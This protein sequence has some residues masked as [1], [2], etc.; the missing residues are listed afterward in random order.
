M[1]SFFKKTTIFLLF[2]SL[3]LSANFVKAA[4]LIPCG[5]GGGEEP[6]RLCHIFVVF[7]NIVEYLL[8][9]S[10]AGDSP[11]NHG[12]PIVLTVAVLLI[13]IGGF[14]YFFSGGNPSTLDKGKKI[15]ISVGIGLLIIYGAW[16][17]VNLFFTIIGVADWTG[18]GEWWH[19]D[20][21][22]NGNGG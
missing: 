5:G 21:N 14:V 1:N 2:I 18:L 22:G 16:L 4:G 3:F 9:P 11:S 19:I 10:S 20:C 17:I 7:N 15:M 13:V 8:I 6:C 12:F